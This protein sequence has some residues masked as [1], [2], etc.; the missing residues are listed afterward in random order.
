[1]A[2]FQPILIDYGADPLAQFLQNRRELAYKQEVFRRQQETEMDNYMSS[3]LKDPNFSK[4][5]PYNPYINDQLNKILLDARTQYKE[6]KINASEFKYT[7]ANRV[8]SLRLWAE[9]ADQIA[10]SIDDQVDYF[11]NKGADV[12]TLKSRA[13]R[14]VF[15]DNNNQ[16]KDGATIANEFKNG[17]YDNIVTGIVENQAQDVFKDQKAI[18]DWL[19][20]F[21]TEKINISESKTV[22]RKGGG[23]ETVASGADKGAADFYPGWQ[24]VQKVGGIPVGVLPKTIDINS[25]KTN[26]A[27]YFSA[28]SAVAQ[29]KGITADQVNDADV[30]SWLT[31]YA[32][33][34]RPYNFTKAERKADAR[35]TYTTNVNVSQPSPSYVDNNIF[36]G[37]M[38]GTMPYDRYFTKGQGDAIV[39]K[40]DIS[41]RLVVGRKTVKDPLG[42]PDREQDVKVNK[43]VMYPN[44]GLIWYQDQD[45]NKNRVTAGTPD[46]ESFMSILKIDNPWLGTLGGM[47]PEA[48]PKKGQKSGFGITGPKQ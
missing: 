1:M 15:M 38:A 14:S 18:D 11:K 17:N 32:N 9:N 20:T 42:G 4:D 43:L 40:P 7:V 26:D 33:T 29:E 24:E 13:Y 6:G 34:K 48:K 44:S 23:V 41:K 30:A 47:Q 28:K 19:N 3:I 27:V 5:S 39:M 16:W 12:S 22:K 2:E 10:K 36:N 45:G 25:I 37:V 46:Y 31:T 35:V 21:K 8:S